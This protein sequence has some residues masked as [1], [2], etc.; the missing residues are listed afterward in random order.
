MNQDSS[1]R[2][3]VLAAITFLGSVAPGS[4]YSTIVDVTPHFTSFVQNQGVLDKGLTL[5]FTYGTVTAAANALTSYNFLVA[6]NPNLLHFDSILQSTTGLDGGGSFATFG[7]KT[8]YTAT[9]PFPNPN[10]S[11]LDPATIA[12]AYLGTPTDQTTFWEGSLSLTDT[13][14]STDTATFTYQQGQTVTLF[15]LVFDVLTDQAAKS[16]IRIMDARNFTPFFNEPLDYKNAVSSGIFFPEER[17]SAQV[18]VPAPAPLLLMAAGLVGF[19]WRRRS[20]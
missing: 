9:Q 18:E 14:N 12:G 5:T 10:T 16:S 13:S 20:A 11:T 2:M 6:Y 15:S 4:A 17:G 3:T 19:G 7:A 1:I 8:N